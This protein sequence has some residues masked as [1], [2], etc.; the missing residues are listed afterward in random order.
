[1]ICD[2]HKEMILQ[3]KEMFPK[4]NTVVQEHQYKELQVEE[5]GTGNINYIYHIKDKEQNSM[6]V[7]YAKEQAR[8]SKDMIVSSARNCWEAEVMKLYREYNESVVPKIYDINEEEHY[9]VMEYINNAVSLKEILAKG[10]IVPEFI[11]DINAYFKNIFNHVEA[12]TKKT[13]ELS[14]IQENNRDLVH[15]TERLVFKEPYGENAHNSY[16]P[17]NK[18]FVYCNLY[19]DEVLHAKVNIAK[20]IFQQQK[21]TL[22][23]GDLHTGSIMVLNGAGHIKI[24]DYEFAMIGPLSYDVGNL[25]AHLTVAYI[26]GGYRAEVYSQFQIWIRSVIQKLFALMNKYGYL[27]NDKFV[28]GSE[29]FCACELIRRAVGIAKF[30]EVYSIYPKH[31]AEMERICI[32]LGRKMLFHPGL[33]QDEEMFFQEILKLIYGS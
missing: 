19:E 7:K 22:I 11:E 3:I 28:E 9:F 30:T 16:A 5:I 27:D 15:L 23:H 6:I 17:E 32:K 29:M 12:L 26:C 20:E 24:L 14:D 2:S 33:F 31:V 21:T 25:I 10:Q 13:E 4:L 1:M 8:I 18:D